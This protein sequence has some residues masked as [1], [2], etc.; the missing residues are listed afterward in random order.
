MT[1]IDLRYCRS[2]VHYGLRDE[3][4]Y[5]VG[6]YMRTVRCVYFTDTGCRRGGGRTCT[7]SG[8][9]LNWLSLCIQSVDFVVFET[10]LHAEAR[11]IMH[12]HLVGKLFNAL[13]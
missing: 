4:W 1:T 13:L 5:G 2:T 9:P 11:A 8:S 12:A 3:G 10:S 6:C 7:R